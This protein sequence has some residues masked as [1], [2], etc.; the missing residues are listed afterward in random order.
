MKVSRWHHGSRDKSKDTPA[1]PGGH[2]VI[3]ALS[4]SMDCGWL[5][6]YDAAGRRLQITMTYEEYQTLANTMLSQLENLTHAH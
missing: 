1:A 3:P 2:P 4:H 5:L 6:F